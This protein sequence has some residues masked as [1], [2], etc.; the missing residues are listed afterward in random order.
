MFT[1]NAICALITQAGE[2]YT[3]RFYFCRVSSHSLA[4]RVRGPCTSVPRY[5][6]NVLYTADHALSRHFAIYFRALLCTDGWKAIIDFK[7]FE[8]ETQI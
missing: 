2:L 7:D 8:F 3:Y 1:H 6:T 5:K 4:H